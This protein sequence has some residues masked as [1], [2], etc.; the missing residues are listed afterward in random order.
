ML[1]LFSI[2]KAFRGHIGVIQR[3]ALKS[4]TLLRPE[5]EILLLGDDEGTAEAAKEFGCVH[6]PQVARNEHGTPLISAIFAQAQQRGRFE[7]QCYVNADI[8][9][10]NDFMRA[11]ERVAR[12]GRPAVAVGHRWD[13]DQKEPL[14][15]A[16]GWEERLRAAAQTQGHK[17]R[18]WLIDYFCFPRGVWG[19]IPPFAVGRTVWD[20]WLLYRV[21][22]RGALLVDIT[23]VAVAV[24][25][26]HDYGHI[27]NGEKG[28]YKGPEAARNLELAGGEEH[29]FSIKDATHVLTEQGLRR[30][31]DRD[32]FKRYL[33]RS[34]MLHPNLKW[35][36][37]TTD[38]FF[39]GPARLLYRFVDALTYRRV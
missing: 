26:N 8:V 7:R 36:A 16:P 21:R 35:L 33:K 28:A 6:V 20:N 39:R 10:M 34:Q 5:C 19:E 3:N 38:R 25:Q 17:Q 12:C 23:P 31:L 4:W 18:D 9:L 24:H 22:E 13:F 32:Q 29:C 37:G 2:P 11:I 1:T 15:F 30:A 27:K 14:D